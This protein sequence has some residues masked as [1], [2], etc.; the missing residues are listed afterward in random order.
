MRTGLFATLARSGQAQQL[1]AAAWRSVNGDLRCRPSLVVQSTCRDRFIAIIAIAM[2]GRAPT[3]GRARRRRAV[4]RVPKAVR[5][6]AS[7]SDRSLNRG[8]RSSGPEGT[9]RPARPRVV[10]SLAITIREAGAKAASNRL[11]RN[12]AD[13]AKACVAFL[14]SDA[15]ANYVAQVPGRGAARAGI[16]PRPGRRPALSAA[17]SAATTSPAV[18]IPN[19]T[20]YDDG[21]CGAP[22]RRSTTR[23]RRRAATR[24]CRSPPT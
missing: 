10:R 11:A 16:E 22:R 17:G 9:L 7:A 13:A 3:S 20:V 1:G 15:R 4:R 6:V 14:I 2:R 19:S 5:C 21:T 18:T 12:R 8:P 23:R 24:A